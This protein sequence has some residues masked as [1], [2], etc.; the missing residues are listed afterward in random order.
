[1]ATLINFF[2]LVSTDEHLTALFLPREPGH[3]LITGKWPVR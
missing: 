1:M 3:I 2:K